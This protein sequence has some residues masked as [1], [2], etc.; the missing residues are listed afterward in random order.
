MVWLPPLIF[1]V[2][3]QND[4]SQ[5]WGVVAVYTCTASCSSNPN[6]NDKNKDNKA[7][8]EELGAYR[9]EFAWVQPALE[10]GM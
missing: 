4:V 10:L 1:S 5:K 2:L 7:D 8:W 6:D 9:E 3:V